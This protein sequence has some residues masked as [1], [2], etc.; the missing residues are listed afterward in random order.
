MKPASA[1]GLQIA[2][3][4]FVVVLMAAP[5]TLWILRLE[6]WAP[7]VAAMIDKAIP[8]LLGVAV[9]VSFRGLRT[10]CSIELNTPVPAEKRAEVAA[11]TVL[12]ILVAFG[13]AGAVALWYWIAGAEAALAH[14]MRQ[15]KS[16]EVEM[17]TAFVPAEMVRSLLVAGVLAPLTEELVF[18][19]LLYR[20]WEAQ[21]GWFTAMLA[22]S[23]LFAA[24]HPNPMPVFVAGIFYACLYRRTGSIWAPIVAH[25]AFNILMWYP[26]LGRLVFPRS[27][28][29]P[30]DLQS[31]A[32]HLA[33]MLLSVVA[34]PAYVSLARFQWVSPGPFPPVGDGALPR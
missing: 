15:L 34:I 25:A 3:L 20:A 16:D 2:F 12:H 13:W 32:F 10:I 29:A 14:L 22:S 7:E 30:G 23:A 24:Y 1:S 19:G 28:E 5:L 21:W 33:A 18:R 8:F 6:R 31:W 4:T 27:L 11:V 26:L 9:L 17:A